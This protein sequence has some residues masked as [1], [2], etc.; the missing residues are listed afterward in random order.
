MT[1]AEKIALTSAALT[2]HLVEHGPE[3][4]EYSRKM[5]WSTASVT[6]SAAWLHSELGAPEPAKQPAELAPIPSGG[7]HWNVTRGRLGNGKVAWT[8]RASHVE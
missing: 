6:V 2:A 5:G 8:A 3:A 1:A 7:L 4:V